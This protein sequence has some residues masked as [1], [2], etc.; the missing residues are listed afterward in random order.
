[1]TQSVNRPTAPPPTY[2]RLLHVD[3]LRTALM[4]LVVVH[5]SV[6]AYSNVSRWY[7][8]EPPADSSGT[9]LDILLVLNQTFFMARLLDVQNI[10]QVT[11]FPRDLHRLA[12]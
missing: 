3:N 2:P 4:A 6:I 1:M 9:L 5:H 12:P 8:L 7:Y 10:R 11:L